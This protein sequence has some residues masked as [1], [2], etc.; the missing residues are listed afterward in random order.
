M[1]CPMGGRP[2]KHYGAIALDKSGK[3]GYRVGYIPKDISV[4]PGESIIIPLNM[5]N[6]FREDLGIKEIKTVRVPFKEKVGK[7]LAGIKD[8][9][10][11]IKAVKL[12]NTWITK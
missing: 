8:E 9:P 7:W 12:N 3:I 10:P 1:N 5:I 11:E 4:Q 2:N 6:Q